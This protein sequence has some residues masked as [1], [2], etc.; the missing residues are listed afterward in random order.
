MLLHVL[1]ILYMIN[2]RNGLISKATR[3][4]LCM[5]SLEDADL[6]SDMLRLAIIWLP[7]AL[8]AAPVTPLAYIC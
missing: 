4:M 2:G 1:H 3:A 5:S 8:T 7:S 6:R